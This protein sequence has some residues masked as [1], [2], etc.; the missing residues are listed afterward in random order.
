MGILGIVLLVC[1]LCLLVA[2]A[3]LVLLIVGIV[4]RKPG[5]WGSGIVIMVLALLL[6]VGAA[7]AGVYVG[8]RKAKHS[9]VTI[10]DQMSRTAAEV[11]ETRWFQMCTGLALPEGVFLPSASAD[12]D[13]SPGQESRYYLHME[14]PR[15]FGAFLDEHFT[16]ADWPDVKD[17]LATNESWGLTEPGAMSFYTLNY[18]RMP[19]DPYHMATY[20]AY[21]QTGGLAYFVSVQVH[22]RQ[23][24]DR[25]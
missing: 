16:K 6:L 1:G 17:A 2:I 7:V 25:R 12:I 23:P 15:T 22:D 21:D 13:P 19:N 14:V 20:I 10:A 11:D 3:G 24:R 18:R 5:M 8:V 4:R 9:V